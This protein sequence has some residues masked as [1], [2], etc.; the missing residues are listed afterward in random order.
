MTATG[1]PVTGPF[2]KTK[3]WL[4]WYDR[5]EQAAASPCP[6]AASTRIAT[7]SARARSSRTRPSASTRPAT[8]AR[9][10]SSRCAIVSA[11]RATSIVQATC[12]GA[13]NSAMVDACLASGGRARGVATVRRSVT[14]RRTRAAARGRRARR[15]LQFRQAPRR[16]HAEGR[17]DG[18]RRPHRASSAGTSSSI[19]RR[20]T[21]PNSG[22]SSPRCRRPSSSTTWAGP[23]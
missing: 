8:P 12:H 2:E 5:P 14:R 13:D 11:L 20:S 3:G 15:A 10:S 18:D 21:C 7:C 17:T 6:P 19:S 1:K 22:T 4:D 16:L 9:R 23:T